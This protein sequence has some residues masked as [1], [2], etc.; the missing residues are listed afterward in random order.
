MRTDDVQ[1]DDGT[2]VVLLR[3]VEGVVQQIPGLGQ[4]VALF[5]PE[6][7]LVDGNTHEVEAQ[8]LQTGEVILLDMQ[9]AGLATLL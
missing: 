6:L 2:Q 3:P 8:L 1:V 5:I 4:L 7:H 9:S